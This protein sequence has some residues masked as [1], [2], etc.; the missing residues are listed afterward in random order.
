MLKRL[1]RRIIITCLILGALGAAAVVLINVHII[2]STKDQVT[3]LQKAAEF[4]EADCILVLGAGVRADG[5][6]SHMLEDRLKTG[7]ALFQ[8]NAAPKML[9]SGDHGRTDYNEV[10]VMK[11]FAVTAGIDSSDIFMDH[12]GFSTYESLYRA[13]DVFQ[14]EHVIIVSQGYHL[15]RA[16]YIANSLGL[17]A[18]GVSADLRTYAGQSM[19]DIREVAARTKDFF[20]CIFHPKPTYLGDAIPVSGNGDLTND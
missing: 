15:Y 9:M 8:N 19:R 12:A 3:I 6:P 20:M 13:R 17:D 2:T 18:V 16:L 1:F 11:D 5:T 14:A 7:V 10:A 4:G